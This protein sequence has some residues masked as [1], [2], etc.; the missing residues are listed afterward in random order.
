MW[1]SGSGSG[2]RRCVKENMSMSGSVGRVA[3][4]DVIKK[5]KELQRFESVLLS[6]VEVK[7]R[8]HT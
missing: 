8:E 3:A 7:A 1:S 6:H 5:M 2:A 4:A